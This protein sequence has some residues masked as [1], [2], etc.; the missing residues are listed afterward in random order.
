[1]C[2]CVYGSTDT[3]ACTMGDYRGKGIAGSWTDRHFG[4]QKGSWTVG[5]DMGSLTRKVPSRGL[6]RQNPPEQD[7][8]NQ[9]SQAAFRH[10]SQ[11]HTFMR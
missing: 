9:W 10:L 2:A 1:M 3:K 5:S 6:L 7:L 11:M 4:L 8:G